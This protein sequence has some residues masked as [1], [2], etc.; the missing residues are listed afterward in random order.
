MPTN[1]E[2]KAR[3][4]DEEALERRI[5]RLSDTGVVVLEQEDTFF[6]TPG[7]RLKLRTFA[8]GTG[9]LISYQRDDALE[10]KRSDY[11]IARVE[12][13]RVLGAVL[14]SALGV[15]GTV[16]KTRSLSMVGTTRIHLDRVEGLGV[17]IELEVVLQAGE[18][19]EDGRATAAAIMEKLQIPRDRLVAGAYVDL[20]FP[21]R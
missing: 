16:R 9:E 20:L 7:R 4:D 13:P 11:L 3:V 18:T 19:E 14:E 2:I 1:I 15:R 5:R 8:D 21:E 10:P 12:A 17:F 6:H